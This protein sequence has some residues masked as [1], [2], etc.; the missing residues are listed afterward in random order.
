MA[1]A[2]EGVEGETA[3]AGAVVGVGEAAGGEEGGGRR[4]PGRR[5]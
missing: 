2:G 1:V 3:V 4:R 5:S